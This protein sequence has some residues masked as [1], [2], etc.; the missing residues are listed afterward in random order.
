M[1]LYPFQEEGVQ[2]MCAFLKANKGCYNA[3]DMGTGKTAMSIVACQ[4]MAFKNILVI[5]RSIM[6]LVW[7]EEIEKWGGFEGQSFILSYN[8]AVIN[9]KTILAEPWDC[10]ILDEAH[11]IKNKDSQRSKV[12][13]KNFWPKIPYKIC[14]SGT[15]FTQSVVDCWTTFSRFSP[16]EFGDYWRFVNRYTNEIRSP[17]GSKYEGIKNHEELSRIIRSKFFLRYNKRDVLPEL[18]GKVWQK[19]S[20]P[21]AYLHR[22]SPEEEKKHEEYL[23]LLRK[24][25]RNGDTVSPRPPIAVATSRLR[26]GEKKI[27]AVIEFSKNLLDDSIPIVLF[28]YS[29]NVLREL[30]IALKTYKTVA[31]NGATTERNR[32]LAIDGFQDGTYNAF[33]G[34]YTAAGVGCTLTRSSTCIFAEP[35]W[36]P[37]DMSQAADRLDRIGQKSVVNCYYFVVPG[38]LDERIIEVMMAKAKSFGKVLDG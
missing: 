4:R 16:E 7:K 10:L 26:Q 2:K 27:Q 19:I 31:V 32:K 28:A 9:G 36:S 38:S 20:L 29:T 37:A 14:L 18:P 5:T 11:Q 13:L 23:E 3:S 34:Q 25:H 22:L 21:Q 1:K 17:F 24:H 35:D 30:E 33:I 6:T 12:I 15:P 8:K